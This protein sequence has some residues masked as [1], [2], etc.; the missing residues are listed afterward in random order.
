MNYEND[1]NTIVL[2]QTALMEIVDQINYIIS[3]N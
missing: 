1:V 2:W 3:R